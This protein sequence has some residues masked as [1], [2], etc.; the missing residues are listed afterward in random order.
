MN[1]R[2]LYF[3]GDL[4]FLQGKTERCIEH[5]CDTKQHKY[6]IYSTSLNISFNI[7]ILFV[8][9]GESTT[10]LPSYLE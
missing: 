10:F 8:I 7:I 1:E 9:K 3:F 5:V 4:M 2:Y 6:T